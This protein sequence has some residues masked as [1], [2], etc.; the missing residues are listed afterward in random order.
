MP[1]T[2]N[3]RIKNLLFFSAA[4]ISH[5]PPHLPP[6]ALLHHPNP[7][8]LLLG[9]H[10]FLEPNSLVKSSKYAS[11]SSRPGYLLGSP[12]PSALA[13]NGQSPEPHRLAW[14]A[15]AQGPVE[16][17][18]GPRPVPGRSRAGRRRRQACKPRCRRSGARARRRR[19]R[20]PRGGTRGAA[21]PAPMTATW[22]DIIGAATMGGSRRR[23]LRRE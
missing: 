9:P 13:R 6:S 22:R 18:V 16:A 19:P 15:R 21:A 4:A 10:Q 20:G 8:D 17:R 7:H 11:T 14:Q 23:K 5:P 3:H 2:N 1:I 12:D